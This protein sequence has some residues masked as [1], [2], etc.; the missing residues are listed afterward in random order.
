MA[1]N[2]NLELVGLFKGLR[3]S[4]STEA[5][6]SVKFDLVDSIQADLGQIHP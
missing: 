6:F 4:S 1:L 3:L 5:K 2:S